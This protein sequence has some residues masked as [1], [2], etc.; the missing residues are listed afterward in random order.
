MKNRAVKHKL[1][2]PARI[3]LLIA[4][5]AILAFAL[6]WSVRDLAALETPFRLPWFALIPLVFLG[7]VAIVSLR[8]RRDAHVFSM[9]ELPLVI[10]LFFINPARLDR[11]AIDRQRSRTW[12]RSSPT[13]QEAR[14]QLEPP[15][16]SGGAGRGRVPRDRH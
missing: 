13:T 9:S 14:V 12:P 3:W 6:A 5:M 16:P 15:H 10:G 8:F 7:E 11:G 1:S 2:N 4:G